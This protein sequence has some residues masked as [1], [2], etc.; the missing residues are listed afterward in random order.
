MK[1]VRAII[2]II[3]ALL[4][5]WLLGP[6]YKGVV[7]IGMIYPLPVLALFMLFSARPDL[8]KLMFEKCKVFSII[9]TSVIGVGIVVVSIFMGMMIYYSNDKVPKNATVIILGCQV[10]GEN[11]SLM[12]YDRMTAAL[13]YIKENPESKIIASGGKG[14]GENISE[15]LA[16]KRFLVKSGVDESRIYLED[17]SVDTYQNL[18]YSANVIKNNNLKKEVVVV[19][20][21]FHEFRGVNYAKRSGLKAFAYSCNTRW[22]FSLSYY[23]REVLAIMKYLINI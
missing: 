1:I 2:F 17:Q 10:V 16:I 9:A 7:H 12:L 6:L 5:I 3:S 8:L 4:F 21:G 19:T 20:D 23:S 22:Y 13:D 11:P 18:N 15:A 14:S